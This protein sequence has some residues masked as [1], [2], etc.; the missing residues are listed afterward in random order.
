MANSLEARVPLLDHKFV[1]FASTIPTELRMRGEETKYIFKKALRGIL[2]DEI[3]YRRKQG[4]AVPLAAWFR[5]S[6]GEMVR[7]LLLTDSSRSA[8][9]VN[10]DYIEKILAM[11]ARGRSMDLQL[12]TLVS[13][14]LWCRRFLDGLSTEAVKVNDDPG[15]AHMA[16]SQS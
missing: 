7:E 10:P 1:E 13:F 8:R 15:L 9:F 5:A 4:F 12:W 2:P 6:L 3:L 16:V 14:E 11:N